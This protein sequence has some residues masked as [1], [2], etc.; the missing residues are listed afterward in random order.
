MQL[1]DT[2]QKKL[3]TQKYTSGN[4]IQDVKK[5]PLKHFVGDEGDFGELMRL[6][7]TGAVE[8]FPEF[9]V[10][11]IS[12]SR[13]EPKAIKGWHIHFNQDEL[14]YVAPSEQLMIGLWDCREESESANTTMR[15]NL[16]GGISQ[17]LYIP[18]GV[19]H[20]C[21]NFT[22]KPVDLIYFMNNTF[23]V[24]APDEQ[25]IPFDTLPDFWKPERD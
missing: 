4:I 2:A 13:V 23:N 24:D 14:W 17:F 15:I 18:R 16:G 9:Q 22:T 19:A 25:R 3:Y 21:T 8:A 20:G 12:R 10:R 5:I 11:Q 6:T 1:I 7:E